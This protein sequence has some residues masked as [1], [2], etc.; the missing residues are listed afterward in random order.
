M[1]FPNLSALTEGNCFIE[2][3]NEICYELFSDPFQISGNA[4][5]QGSRKTHISARAML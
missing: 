3:D 5:I 2:E 4:L 1:S